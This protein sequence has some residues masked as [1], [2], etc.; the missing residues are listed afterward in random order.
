ME[1][2]ADWGVTV[3]FYAAVHYGRAFLAG[4][5]NPVTTHQHF[6][7]V[8]VRVTGDPVTYGYYRALQTESE[9]S[10]YDCANYEWSDVDALLEANLRPFKASLVKLGLP[11]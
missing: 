5:S 1:S 6:Q 8:F 7:A 4:R 11:V 10:R 3:L 9:A 2:A